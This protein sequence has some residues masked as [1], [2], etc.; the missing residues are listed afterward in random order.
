[1]P[2]P[3]AAD[4][5]VVTEITPNTDLTATNLVSDAKTDPVVTD[6]AKTDDDKV[7]AEVKPEDKLETKTEYTDFTMPEG[8]TVDETKLT[9]F[10]AIAADAGL[11][12]ETA[13]KFIDLYGTQTKETIEAPYK[14]WKATQET[15]QNEVKADPEIGGAKLEG[16]LSGIAKMIDEIGGEK[17]ADVRQALNYT[18]AGNNPA[19]IKFL[20]RLS[21]QFNE[22]TPVAI[23]KPVVTDKSPGQTL[24]P[25]PPKLA[26]DRS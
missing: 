8:I 16:T 17:A 22:P 4:A 11:P 13:Q 5:P 10:K 25:N 2:E 20:A 19:V 24:Y 7:V 14:L 23:G 3:I 21:Q 26:N 15:W 6:E 1:M 18:G 12:Q 9:E